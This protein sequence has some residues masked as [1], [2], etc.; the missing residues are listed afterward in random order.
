MALRKQIKY[1]WRLFLPLVAII[2]IVIIAMGVWMYRTERNLKVENL[3][4]QVALISARIIHAYENNIDPEYF[5]N[6]VEYYYIADKRFDDIRITTYYNG[7]LDRHVGE[8]IMRTD[9]SRFE[10][11]TTKLSDGETD[12]ERNRANLFYD[13]TKSQD[14]RLHIYTMLPFD[15]EVLEA[16]KASTSLYILLI[17]LALGGTAL[18]WIM[19]RRLGRNIRNLRDFAERASSD[20][21]FVPNLKFSKD[22]LGDISR[23]IVSFYNQRNA[24]IIKIKREHNI[25]YHA[26]EDKTRLKRELTNNI[27]HEVKTPVAVVKGYLDTIIQH[28]EMDS[29]SRQH[30]LRK[31]SEHVDRLTQLLNDLSS[32]TR[33]EYGS[34]MI[35][36]EPVNFHEIV[37]QCVC[38]FETSGLLHDMTFNYDVPTY[39]KVIG[40]ETL[41]T[42]M[43]TN[44]TKNA[45][46][47]SK[48][49]ECNLILTDKDDQFYHFAFYDNGVGVKPESLPHLF[50]RFFREDNGRSRK[51]GGTG[52]GLSIVQSTVEA[53]GGTISAENRSGGGLIFRFT[54]RRADQKPE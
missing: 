1:Q 26:L 45:V 46:A 34:Q 53:L 19:S 16:T 43:I 5:F 30:F 29:E 44:L 48:G 21:D 27:T 7:R 20:P 47:Y 54:L 9:A 13:V 33:L 49:T 11:G 10:E 24:A 23:H 8:P 22:E 36:T 2:W 28:P 51:K 38:D 42:A 40:N 39:C 35:T 18:A 37:F 17:A 15:S 32:I 31:V 52:L 14:N 25:A 50:D 3:R 6:F 4:N 41:L 12:T